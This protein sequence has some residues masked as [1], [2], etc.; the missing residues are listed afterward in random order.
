MVNPLK[1]FR[2][3]ASRQGRELSRPIV[4]F[5]AIAAMREMSGCCRIMML[6]PE[7][8][9]SD[10]DHCVEDDHAAEGHAEELRRLCAVALHPGEEAPPQAL[11]SRQWPCAHDVL[12]DEERA[13]LR[14][15]PEAASA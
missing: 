8:E 12:A 11:P 9:V 15:D 5:S 1:R 3:S 6:T 7:G 4:P 13:V 10:L 14:E 2:S